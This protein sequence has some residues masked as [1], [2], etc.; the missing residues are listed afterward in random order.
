M[1]TE[2]PLPVVFLMGPTAAGKTRLALA[3][4][5]RMPCEI[6]S[7]D[8]AMVYRGLDIGTDKPPPEVL[9]RHPHRLV[10][11]CDPAEPY[12]A[13]RFRRDALS[14]I[15]AALRAGRLPLLVGGTGLYFRSL[16][17]GLSRL[18]AA[19]PQVR[20][21]LA[22][23]ARL[24]GWPALHRRLRAADPETARRVHPHDRQR[25]QRALEVWEASGRP[26]SELQRRAPPA[27]PEFRP[28]RLIVAPSERQ[29]L[30]RRI[31][32]RFQTMLER[33]LVDEVR[34]L[35]ARNGLSPGL[36]ALR[37]AGYRQVW[38]YLQGELRYGEMQAAAIAATRQIAK[39][40]LTWLR[41]ETEALRFDSCRCDL[42]DSVLAR[43]AAAGGR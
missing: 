12:S 43:L 26:L 21:R 24:R 32:N 31:E 6:I 14:C 37:L 19:S 5:K 9:R 1:P 34:A 35:R 41:S 4:C 22:R 40:Q 8:S 39:R 30:Y 27:P 3:L 15:A 17:R 42:Q 23:E 7:V 20:E 29:W 10:D 11:I 25:I 2:S 33:G 38:R 13:G 18:P 36:P 28:L 16:T